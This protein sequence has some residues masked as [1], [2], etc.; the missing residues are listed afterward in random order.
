MPKLQEDTAAGG[1]HRVGHQS[2]AFDLFTAV[3]TWCPGI[4]LPL[5][6]DLGCFADNE[7]L[8]PVVRSSKR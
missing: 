5:H 6:R 3:D 1:V 7:R 2:P 8:K 4:T